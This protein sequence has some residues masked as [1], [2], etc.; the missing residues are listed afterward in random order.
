MGPGEAIVLI[1]A[2]YRVRADAYSMVAWMAPLKARGVSAEYPSVTCADEHPPVRAARQEGMDE[3]LARLRQAILAG[4]YSVDTRL[5]A[6]RLLAA[7]VLRR[8]AKA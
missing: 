8:V 7:G 1:S 5:L 2:R 3:R 6:E 4:E